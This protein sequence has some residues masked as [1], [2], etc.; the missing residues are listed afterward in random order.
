MSEVYPRW[1]ESVYTYVMI[2]PFDRSFFKFFIAFT[3]VLLASFSVLFVTGQ[4]IR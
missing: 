3:M 4:Y 2:N 1:Y